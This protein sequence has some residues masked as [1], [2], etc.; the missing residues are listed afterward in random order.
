MIIKTEQQYWA[1]R[2]Q[3][4]KFQEELAA[5]EAEPLTPIIEDYAAS[6]QS[7]MEELIYALQEFEAKHS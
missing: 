5:L 4:E 6:L 7:Q 3:V 2:A 1:I